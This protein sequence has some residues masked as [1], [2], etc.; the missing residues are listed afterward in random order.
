MPR[1]LIA[2]LFDGSEHEVNLISVNPEDALRN[3]TKTQD[4]RW[5]DVIGGSVRY[6]SIVALR[7]VEETD[8]E[9]ERERAINVL[10]RELRGRR[11]GTLTEVR[12]E[13]ERLRTEAPRN[14]R[15]SPA[16][17][18]EAPAVQRRAATEQ[19]NDEGGQ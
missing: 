15:R 1:R 19:G 8:D 17:E 13:L 16:R 12:R 7:I 10:L 11:G 2:R 18:P 4:R 14:T 3:L 5:V 6:D 9:D